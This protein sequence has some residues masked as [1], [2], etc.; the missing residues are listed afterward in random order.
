M[1][2]KI[3]QQ[4]SQFHPDFKFQYV[5]LDNNDSSLTKAMDTL[6][7]EL[8][9]I[10]VTLRNCD[11][12]KVHPSEFEK[13][14]MMSNIHSM[15]YMNSLG[16][17]LSKFVELLKP[18]GELFMIRSGDDSPLYKISEVFLQHQSRKSFALSHG[19]RHNL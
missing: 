4:I 19:R 10:D 18:A 12:E 15:T 2:K 8:K 9:N 3:L 5:G 14:D 1:D 6:S 16:G 11:V 17:A 7:G 13:F